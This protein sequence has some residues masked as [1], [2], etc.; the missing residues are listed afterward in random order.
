M[1]TIDRTKPAAEPGHP[2]AGLEGGPRPD[3]HPT[4][5]FGRIGVLLV[6]LGTPEGTDYWSMRRYLKEFLS[7]RRV[8]EVPRAIWWPLLNLVILSRRPQRSGEAYEQVWNKELDESPLK[9]ITRSQ[10]DRLAASLAADPRIEV[11]WAMRYGLPPIAER[12]EA[13]QRKGCERILIVPL[14]P[15]YAAATTA[16]VNDKAFDALKTMRWQPAIR[17]APQWCDDPVY[18][19]ALARSMEDHLAT[20]DFEPELVLTSYHGV[21]KSY[22]LK[23]DPYHCQC[24]KTT[25]LLR[26]RL[27]WPEDRLRVTFQSR[28]G[29]EE[30]L[31]P[32]TDE[33]V[34]ALAQSGVKR[35]AVMMPGFVADCLETI[36]EIGVENAG[37][38]YEN[39]GEK[40]SAIPCLND[41]DHGMRV[42]ENVVRRE[43]MGWL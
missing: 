15:Q 7:D 42:I 18:I 39:G 17:T 13:L 35:L 26:E 14:Y 6:N 28:F 22:L 36:E 8:I 33:T 1:D 9:T 34:K 29:R 5:S 25:R 21:P 11:D 43:L 40:F 4:V 32:Y 27:G 37:Y 2:H 23:G 41:S 31:K 3:D 10:A 38:F 24:L 30:W 19:D 12:L 20:L 16:T